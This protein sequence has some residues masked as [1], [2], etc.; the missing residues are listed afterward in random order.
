[1]DGANSSVNSSTVSELTE[2]DS[3]D[4]SALLTD[5]EIDPDH[6]P[7]CSSPKSK[8]NKK[9]LKLLKASSLP[10][11]A[12]LNARSLYNK[13]SNFKTFVT[14]LGIEA[15]IISETWE[16]EDKPLKDLL[17]MD[18]YKVHS[19]RRPKVKANRQP[20]GACALIY[21]EN[22][23]DVTNL[24][25]HVPKGVEACWSVFKPKNKT[26]LIEYIAI[27]SVYVSPNSVYKTATI[28]HVI[29]TI[30]L[31]RAKFDN[32][33]NY[34]IGG[35]LNRLKIDKIL[36]CYGPLRQI[37][38]A[39]TRHSATLENII[40]DLHTLYQ[41]PE[42]LPPLQVDLDK[43]GKDSDHNIVILPPI[44][45]SNNN[46]RKKRPVVTRPLTDSGMEQFRQFI[47]SHN[48]D[49]V[50][51][52]NCIDQKVVNFHSTIR[53]KLD[54]YFPEQ[55]VM[56]SYLDKKW[57]NPTLKTLLRK[58]KREFYKRRKS[59]K[60]KKLKKKFKNL[61]RKTV[62]NFYS[63][64]VLELK[65]SNP[66]K[67]YS[68]A[69]RLG[70]EQNH[71]DGELK[72][73][74]LNGLENEVAAEKVAEFFS[75]VSKEYSPLDVKNLPAYLPA[76]NTLK[77]DKRDVAER[78]FKLKNRKS[79]QPIDL[80]SKVRNEFAFELAT[81][82][83]D[84]YDSCLERYHYPKLWKHEW[85]VPAQKTINPKTLKDLRKI[86]LTS[87]FSLVF[88]GLMKDWILQDIGPKID[89]AQYGNQKRT[90]TE[91]MVVK[92]MD[93]ILKL[94]DQNPHRSAV[95]AS[96]LD[97]SSAFD[98]QDPTLA[99]EKFL[100]LGVRPALV[101][102]LV[103]YLTDREMQVKF[104]GKYSSTHRLP[105]GGPQ[106]T[107][108]GLIEYLVQSNDNADCVDVDM[109][110]KYV[111][112]LTVL[113]LVLLT[114]ILTEYNFKQ[115]V[116]S[117]I[118]T[119]ELYVPATHLKSQQYI[120]KIA[121]WTADNQMKL[122]TDKS[123]YMVF[124]RSHTEFATRLSMENNTLD[125]VEEVKLVGIWITTYLDWEKNTHEMCKKAFARITMLTKLKYVG[126]SHQ[127]LIDVYIL[128]IRSILEYCSVVWHSTLTAEQSNSIENVQ[129]LCMKIILGP[130]Y[131]GYVNSL[132]KCGLETL[133]SRREAKCLKFGLKCLLHPI[134]SKLFPVNPHIL[135]E[136]NSHPNREH[137]TVNWARTDSYRMSAVPYIQR[138]LNKHV[139]D[140]QK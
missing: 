5:E 140:Q 92:L 111:D 18:N 91:H 19:H 16:R 53:N 45:I 88:E 41:A 107:L 68:M 117:D 7:F 34:L 116:A 15:A 25:V 128:Y 4:D 104:N 55:V 57:M 134:H 1:M 83:T 69:K 132:E 32:K 11:I 72:V 136:N 114:G 81:P 67:W 77:V 86:S 135:S 127:D 123:N 33:I 122:N 28:K 39:P 22:R 10:L 120:D 115:H 3:D 85:V 52:E 125:R 95:V 119:D 100:K 62:R 131:K 89:P 6:A 30:H 2:D 130:D 13:N 101:P 63:N 71:S 47:S 61:K 27:A 46:Q 84:I 51:G 105:G 133:E 35:D 79:T 108:I 90:S 82:L 96:M 76:P 75:K 102:V 49:E 110:F 103:S 14:E 93:K 24:D 98:R 74:C 44:T 26:D 60:W 121:A 8:P 87:E 118:G 124:S 40:T 50:L 99:I 73:E 43:E 38:T 97:W 126:T 65:E 17:Q 36:D 37:I 29:E 58:I 56:V 64:F 48:W 21:N 138:M 112:D 78:I 31:L 109:R 113:E 139:K 129:K 23:F 59:P 94:I 54:E 66:A 70:A 20:G 42:C 137:F 80:P 106:G 9:K 12:L